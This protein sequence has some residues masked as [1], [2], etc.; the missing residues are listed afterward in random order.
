[1]ALVARGRG[2]AEAIAD[3]VAGLIE[4]ERLIAPGEPVLVLVSAGGDSTLSAALLAELG[5]PLE[6]LHVRHGLRGVESERDAERCRSLA[7]E[8]GAAYREAEG[9]VTAGGNLEA[10][11]RDRRRA[12]ALGAAGGRPLVT[13]HTASD[14][15]ETIL[16]RLASSPSA[17]GAFGALPPADGPWRRPLLELTRAE[18]RDELARR[19]LAF[20]DDPSNLQ[21]EANARVGI[22]L[23]AVAALE[24]VN[25]AAVANLVAA[26]ADGAAAIAFVDRA[27]AALVAAD[28]SLDRAALAVA[29]PIVAARALTLAAGAAGVALD[30]RDAEDLR[31]RPPGRELEVSLRGGAVARLGGGRLRFLPPGAR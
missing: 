10:R 18:V 7:D 1:V 23:D 29:P 5:H 11:L 26:A 30:R 6:L 8:L 17:A 19:G 9:C 20:R 13:G 4:R 16:L 27:A 15:A 2:R 12:A 28:G 22:R 25:P 3:R 14:R 21:R 31:G 24:R